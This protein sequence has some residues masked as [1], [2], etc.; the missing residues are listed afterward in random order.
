[1]R[2]ENINELAKSLAIFQGITEPIKKDAVNP[3]FKSK[4]ASLS[5]IIEG[6]K[7][8]L[9]ANG[10]SYVQIIEDGKLITVLMHNSGQFIESSINIA[11]EKKDIQ[12]LGSYLT[13]LRRYSLSAILGIATEEDDDGNNAKK[14]EPNTKPRAEPIKPAADMEIM[15]HCAE[16]MEKQGK[17]A[18]RAFIAGYSLNEAQ[19]NEIK[20]I[21]LKYEE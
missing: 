19:V 6:I 11:P 9:S 8:D 16:I 2:S 5:G 7:V 1:M 12:S 18:A 20:Q 21:S 15:L 10:L 17:K 13:Y 3:F 14:A 4:Y